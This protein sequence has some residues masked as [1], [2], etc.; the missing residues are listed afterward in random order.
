MQASA[1][2]DSLYYYCDDPV[3]IWHINNGQCEPYPRE[4][5]IV[6]SYL[7]SFP[8]CNRGFIDVGGHIGTQ[9]LPYSKLFQKVFAFEPNKPSYEL[10]LKNIDV[11]S[12]KNVTVYN[13]GAYNKTGN[14]KVVQ[15]SADNTGCFYIQ[16]CDASDSGS[17]PV[18]KIDD[19]MLGNECDVPIDFLKI[20]TEGSEL[21]VLEG[22]CE[23]ITKYKPLIQV[24]TNQS[25]KTYFGYDKERVFDFMRQNE[26]RVFDDDGNNPLF[27]GK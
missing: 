27:F 6:K 23:T 3:F 25:S 13:K 22:A 26:Y 9:S 16:E 17:V 15:H 14:C 19:F 4:L 8:D 10:F 20:D 24:E 7:E 2:Y 18:V 1:Q 5:N 12:A 11:N 21:Y